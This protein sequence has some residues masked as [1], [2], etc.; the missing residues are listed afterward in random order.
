MVLSPFGL[1]NIQPT[2]TPSLDLE[3]SKNNF[4]NKVLFTG[5]STKLIHLEL[6]VWEKF[7]SEI[8]KN[9]Q[10][11]V[12]CEH[13]NFPRNIQQNNF[14][15]CCC[16]MPQARFLLLTL[17]LCTFDV[18]LI[19]LWSNL[20][21]HCRGATYGTILFQSNGYFLINPYWGLVHKIQ[22]CQPQVYQWIYTLLGLTKVL[23]SLD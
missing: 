15:L 6:S 7:L 16:Y 2:P 1:T 17:S 18:F 23:W 3:P 22:E 11:K 8:K 21:F 20:V 13:W 14:W 9:F 5:L 19:Q 10:K 4:Q 12:K